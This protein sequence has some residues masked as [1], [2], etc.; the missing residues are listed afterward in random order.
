MVLRLNTMVFD[1]DHAN[2]SPGFN[3]GFPTIEPSYYNGLTQK[4]SYLMVTGSGGRVE[5][6]QDAASSIYEAADSSYAQLRVNKQSGGPQTPTEEVTL[7]V[8]TTDGT[9]MDY[10][11][12]AGA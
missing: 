10:S 1:A 12:K 6:R 7:T 8:T 2:V 11:W 4:F 3:F 5:F 9:K